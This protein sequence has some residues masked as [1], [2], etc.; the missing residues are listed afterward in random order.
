MYVNALDTVAAGLIGGMN[1]DFL[2]KLPQK[3]RG[4]LG[5]LSVLFHNLQKTL[6][7]DCLRL[8]GVYNS[9][10]IRYGL[11]QFRLLLFVALGQLGKAFLTQ[12][13]YN[14]IFIKPLNDGIQLV[15][16]P[17]LLFQLTL[18]LFLLGAL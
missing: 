11:F 8:S 18:G 16:A 13:T 1:N 6:D 10:Q 17:L 14:M 12:L 15:I 5:G 3:R 4:Q 2:Y 9:G 7:I